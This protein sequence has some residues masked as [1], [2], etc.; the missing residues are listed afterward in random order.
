MRLR[1]TGASDG[2]LGWSCIPVCAAE[3]TATS[4]GTTSVGAGVGFVRSGPDGGVERGDA[5]GTRFGSNFA[6]SPAT[7][8]LADDAARFGGLGTDAA[9]ETVTGRGSG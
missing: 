8:T 2:G 7:G 6:S 3:T 5:A 1:G 4:E 9:A